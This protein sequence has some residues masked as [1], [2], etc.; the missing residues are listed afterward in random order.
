LVNERCRDCIPPPVSMHPTHT[1]R[2][3][4]SHFNRPSVDTDTDA[5]RTLGAVMAWLAQ[6]LVIVLREE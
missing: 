1:K 4:P 2:I 3:A 6:G 5:A